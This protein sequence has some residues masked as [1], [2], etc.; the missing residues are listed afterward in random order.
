MVEQGTHN[1]LVA[2]SSPAGPTTKLKVG[3]SMISCNRLF[4]VHH[5]FNVNLCVRLQLASTAPES[6]RSA[7]SKSS[8]SLSFDGVR[9][10]RLGGFLPGFALVFDYGA[11]DMS[12]DVLKT[13]ILLCHRPINP[14]M[15]NG[16]PT[17]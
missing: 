10:I 13:A 7:L 8:R 5:T 9:T 11:P 16:E 2:G 4:Y 15:I 14:I 6:N 1:P 17:P 12:R 3:C